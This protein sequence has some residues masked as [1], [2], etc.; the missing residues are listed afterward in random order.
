MKGWITTVNT[1]LNH[2]TWYTWIAHSEWTR[3]HWVAIEKKG[4]IGL[5]LPALAMTAATLE[6]ILDPTFPPCFSMTSFNVSLSTLPSST[7]VTPFKERF[8]A[9]K[10]KASKWTV[11]T[12]RLTLVII[13]KK[14][15]FESRLD[16]LSIFSIFLGEVSYKGSSKK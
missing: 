7:N 6:D 8:T 10:A 13:F 9:L 5:G 1:I 11:W 14:L 3:P 15:H 12:T 16:L 2:L 4:R